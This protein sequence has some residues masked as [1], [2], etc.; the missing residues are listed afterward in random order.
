MIDWNEIIALS[1][2]TVLVTLGVQLVKAFGPG[3]ANVWKQLLALVGG[4]LL[5]M[6][7]QPY[8]SG[9][10]GYPIDLSALSAALTGLISGLA[11]MGTFDSA[12]T[13]GLLKK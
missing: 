8:L 5:M 10:L 12:K 7:L 1:I 13:A 4:P 6:F 9:L 3:L 11:A 2:N